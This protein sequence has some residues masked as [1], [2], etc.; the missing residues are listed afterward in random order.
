MEE[1]EEREGE[2]EG[3]VSPD[4]KVGYSRAVEKRA[5]W[6]VGIE[7]LWKSSLV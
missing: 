5:K 2:E 1:V 4:N 3:S 7:Q 6:G